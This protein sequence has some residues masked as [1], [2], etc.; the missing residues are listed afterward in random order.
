[1]KS[2]KQRQLTRYSAPRRLSVSDVVAQVDATEIVSSLDNLCVMDVNREG[3]TLPIAF[4]STATSFRSIMAARFLDD[5]MTPE[6]LAALTAI[7]A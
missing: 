6:A 7:Y 2:I 1:M 4:A 5:F 3:P